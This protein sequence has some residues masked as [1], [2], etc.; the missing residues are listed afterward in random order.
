MCS[1]PTKIIVYYQSGCF[2]SDCQNEYSIC[3]ELEDIVFKIIAARY[4]YP[5]CDCKCIQSVLKTM[6][7]QTSFIIKDEGIIY[8]YNAKVMSNAVFGTAVGEIEA[9]MALLRIMERFCNY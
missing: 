6:A 8:R 5:T 9:S 7:Q 1:T 4:P 2:D 3:K